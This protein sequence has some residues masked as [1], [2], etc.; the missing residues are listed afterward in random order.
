MQNKFSLYNFLSREH[1]AQWP[2]ISL[3]MPTHRVKP[4]NQQDPIAFKNLL[5]EAEKQLIDN[6]AYPRRHWQQAIDRLKAMH[7]D[8]AFWPYTTEGL[9]VLAVGDEVEVFK[10][11]Y[12]PPAQVHVGQHFHLL[13]LLGLF[14]RLD[15]AYLVDISRDRFAAYRVN[16]YSMEPVQPG[17]VKASFPELFRDFD[18]NADLNVGTY[19]GLV[20]THHGHRAKPEEIEKDRE[21]YFRYLD[22]AFAGIHKEEGLP[23][24][25][26]GTTENIAAYR[27]IAK[28][29]F[30]TEGAID[31]PLHSLDEPQ[32]LAHVRDILTPLYEDSL[33]KVSNRVRQA[34]QDGKAETDLGQMLAMAREGRVAELVADMA[35]PDSQQTRLDEIIDALLQT[36]AELTVLRDSADVM[37]GDAIAILRY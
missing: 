11:F 12:A 4:D 6:D 32:I 17:D 30:Y 13:P 26:A 7:E 2:R 36:G 16:R 23:F 14:E 33:D 20:G 31:Q 5:Q 21:K 8:D 27:A 25:L 29:N 35:Q 10:L 3:Y 28:G 19:S 22:D 18:P 9:A 15:A 37:K 1:D 34:R 24:I